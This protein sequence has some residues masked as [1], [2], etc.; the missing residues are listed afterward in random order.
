MKE[1]TGK[2]AI[3]SAFLLVCAFAF[4]SVSTYVTYRTAKERLR[5]FKELGLSKNPT[6]Q[7]EAL[8]R[9]YGTKLRPLDGC[10]Q[11][12]CQYEIDL[13]NESIAALRLVP[14]TK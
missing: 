1:A 4:V 12:L 9:K 5:E 3:G 14:Y 10:S 6:V 7:F 8:R 13:S 2:I 11:R